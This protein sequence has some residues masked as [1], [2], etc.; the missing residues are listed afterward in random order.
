MLAVIGNDDVASSSRVLNLSLSLGLERV[1]GLALG[2]GL[3]LEPLLLS[4]SA[5]RL[6]IVIAGHTVG[7]IGILRLAIG[8][9]ALSLPEARRVAGD[10]RARGGAEGGVLLREGW[11]RL[12]VCFAGGECGL[13]LLG[14]SFTLLF[15]LPELLHGGHLVLAAVVG[16]HGGR[17]DG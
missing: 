7:V 6:V 14:S 13:V 5:L 9:S 2:H 3:L 11:R 4:L 15:N 12:L 8:G 10:L 17:R 16:S 1:G